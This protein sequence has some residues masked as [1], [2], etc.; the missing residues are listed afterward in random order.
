MRS[1]G[2]VNKEAGVNQ[3]YV[4][5]GLQRWATLVPWAIRNRVLL[6]HQ[7]LIVQQ[8]SFKRESSG[9]WSHHSLRQ[10]AQHPARAP[11]DDDA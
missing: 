2:D 5:Y 3:W 11:C 6:R 1:P 7:S 4:G 9:E 8:V 10:L